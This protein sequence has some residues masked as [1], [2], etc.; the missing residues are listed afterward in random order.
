MN[1]KT[2]IA[3]LGVLSVILLGTTVFF[4]STNN[5]NNPDSTVHLITTT[6]ANISAVTTNEKRVKTDEAPWKT[7]SSRNLKISFKYPND[8]HVYEEKEIGFGYRIYIQS[9]QIEDAI[10]ENEP[11]ALPDSF[12]K[13]WISNWEQETMEREENNLKNNKS[14]FSEIYG[15]VSASI[16]QVNDVEIRTYDYQTGQGPMLNAYWEN[17]AG[18]RYNATTMS[19]HGSTENQKEMIENLRKILATVKSTENADEIRKNRNAGNEKD[20]EKALLDDMFQ[21]YCNNTRIRN[22]YGMASGTKFYAK[23]IEN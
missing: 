4:A 17:R 8:W 23:F 22:L 21:V 15:Q 12:Q 3:L 1:Q 13:V 18:E 20:A 19:E 9:S 16:I 14:D 6:G 2:I 11:S 5:P 10:N 7:Y